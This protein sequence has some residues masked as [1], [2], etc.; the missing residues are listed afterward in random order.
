MSNRQKTGY[1]LAVLFA[2]NAMNFYD[3]N[4]AGT[5]AEPIR[6]EFLLSDTALGLLGT[7]F[8]L[9]YAA[10]GLPLGHLSD[11]MSRKKILS[12][13]VALWSVFTAA[14]G[15]ARSYP[16][17][18]AARLGVG[19]GEASCA[20]A[21]SSLIGDL[22]PA[23]KRA[24]AL[25]VFMLGLPIGIALSNGFS[26]L[27]AARWGWRSA[28]YIAAIPGLVCA[29]A[30]MAILEPRRGAAEIHDVGA[31]KRAGSPFWLVLSTPT[32]LWVIISG[33][34][35]NFN[36]YAL[37]QFMVPFLMR[38]HGMHLAGAN[39]VSMG[40]YGISGVPGLLLGGYLGDSIMK[41][42]ADG[43][44]LVGTVALVIAAPLMFFALRRGPGDITVFSLLMGTGIGV[45][46]AYYST[47]YSTIQDVVE[48]SLRGTAMALYFFAMY[49][50]GASIGTLATGMASDHF[51]KKAA[52]AAGVTNLVGKALEPYKAQGLH[53]ALLIIP[54]LALLLALVLFAGSR[55][56]TG[57]VEKL[58]TWMR[59]AAI[60]SELSP[61]Q[62]D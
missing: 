35:H 31:S 3:R 15:L 48:P 9:L 47:V 51:T 20:P 28:F 17:L 4:L 19:V 58:H 29:L 16:Q 37:G 12:Y 8:T 26:A 50:M 1:A 6:K 45:M 55:T 24:K 43:R 27:V 57:D 59:Q 13:G 18:F 14:S 5:V 32:M 41:R 34:L 10:V 30:A 40:I 44:M 21:A 38:Y 61:A 49:V 23:S 11:R 53:S 52:I 60:E 42:R 62:G 33:A 36:M 7:A 54:A 2:M 56:V 25:G 39:L 46:Y 22:F